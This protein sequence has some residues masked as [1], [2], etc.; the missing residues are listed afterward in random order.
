MNESNANISL[1][2]KVNGV[3][4]SLQAKPSHTLLEALRDGLGLTGSKRG[5]EDGTCGSCNVVVNG[6]MARAC[7][8]S[9][10]RAN[11]A[12]VLTIEGLGSGGALDPLQRAFID[13]DAVQCGFCTPGMIM[14][15]KVLL[16]R[17][18]H[19]T[20]QEIER[21]LG[22]NL[23]RCTG[24]ASIIDAI[25]TVANSDWQDR[26]PEA[27]KWRQGP[28]RADARDKVIGAALYADDLTMP[29]MLHAAVLRSPHAHAEI[30]EID[31]DEAR[32]LP[33][34][35]AVVTAQDVP[36]LNR[37]GRVIKDQPV[38]A[39]DKARQMGDPVA[40]VAAVS[41]EIAAQA[42]SLV[43]VTYNPLPSVL[44]ASEALE[45]SAPIVHENSNLLSER[46]LYWGDAKAGSD[47]AELVV[48]EA[49][50]TARSDH[51]YLEPDAA[52][53]YQDED[54]TLVMRSATQ[55]SFSQQRALAETMDLSDDQVRFVPTAVG[56]AFGGK[57]DP[58]YQS[59]VALLSLKTGRP[60]KIV[61][62]REESFA[63]TT[64]RH[65]FKIRLQTG[66][67]RA[68]KLTTLN[69][70]MIAD[71]GAYASSGPSIFVR[72]GVSMVGPY[73]F[74]NGAIRGRSVY[75]NNPVS[76]SMRGFGAPQSVFAMESQM[77]TMAQR[78]GIDPLEFRAMNR[79]DTDPAEA[80]PQAAEQEKSYQAT[81]DA[82][83]P[84]YRDATQ[85]RD[86]ENDKASGR[87]RRGVGV[88]SMRYGVGSA[89]AL[90]SP[91][92]ATLELGPDGH[93]RVFTGIME[94][95]QGSDTVMQ[96]IVAEEL[97]LPQEQVSV[98]SGDTFMTPDAGTSGGS[99]STYYVGN[100]AKNGAVMLKE[101][102]LSTASG[103]LERPS[104]ELEMEDGKVVPSDET[105][106]AATSVSLDQV[107]QARQSARLPLRFD[108]EFLPTH[109]TQEPPPGSTDLFPVYV[110]ATHMAEVEV[111]MER[112]DVRVIRM[113]A[114]HDVGRAVFPQGLKGQIEGSVSMGLGQ[115]IKEEYLPGETTG[116]KQYRIPTAREMP[117][118][119]AL[120]VENTDPS[121]SLGAK[122]AAECALVPVAPAIANAIA[123]ATGV[124][125]QDLPITPA[126]LLAALSE[127]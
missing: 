53:A 95:G 103:M 40:A 124:R 2:F 23:C 13:A 51:A 98:V 61:Y 107:A 16:D 91:G 127:A 6:R 123:N 126:R 3:E 94:L 46:K 60:V 72:S 82:V 76:G 56:G 25:A 54:G 33:G 47:Q 5:C 122:G 100:A 62:S 112:G 63:A 55:H 31:L 78:L 102:V 10:G 22:A 120:L 64:K 15:A 48:D 34:V 75:T 125:V 90:D 14:A 12:D 114:A 110:S 88:A 9:P 104:G 96:L 83:R 28:E 37:Y 32:A 66:V 69:A 30:V 4:H 52:L 42:V 87:W 38:L 59:I 44:D 7:Q 26:S 74:P 97:G 24:Y 109:V 70:E 43:K 108:G 77:D 85:A 41:P 111:D 92:R 58:T 84:Y 36:G 49:Y 80:T 105:G 18:P 29:N 20:K 17:N 121:A 68:G 86:V 89:S 19:P 21:A 117:E 50:T 65:P 1:S 35:E 11:G 119:V 79:R 57:N 106:G 101:A 81:I 71:T 93:V 45:E 99:R 73:H 115:A 118:V 67:T 39:D 8:V 116:F 113:V 27:Q